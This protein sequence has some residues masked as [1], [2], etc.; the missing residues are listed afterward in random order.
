MTGIDFEILNF[1]QQH[2][3]SPLCDLLLLLITRLGDFGIFWLVVACVLAAS[4]K[5]RFIGLTLL[6]ALVLN[7]LVSNVLLKAIVA[8]PRPCQINPAIHLLINCPGSF[9][10]PSGHSSASF[11]GAMVL[12]LTRF[13]YWPAFMALAVLIGFSRLYLYV[14]FPSD[15]IAGA[16]GGL[17]IGWAAYYLMRRFNRH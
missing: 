6:L 16:L 17:A 7:Y 14:H 9:S 15:V 13:K 1:I 12:A 4:K 10:F 3:R 11:A 5:Y 8:R 2:L